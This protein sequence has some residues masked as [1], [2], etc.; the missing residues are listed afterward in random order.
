MLFALPLAQLILARPRTIPASH[1]TSSVRQWGVPQGIVA[2]YCG[3]WGG[4]K[5]A[6]SQNL[7][8]RLTCA[9][10]MYAY[11]LTTVTLTAGDTIKLMP[12]NS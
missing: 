10:C 5:L 11:Q 1:D 6:R 12:T 4:A 2:D 8:A 3:C 9:N 7:L